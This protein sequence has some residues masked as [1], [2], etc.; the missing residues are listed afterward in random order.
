[1][2]NEFEFMIAGVPVLLSLKELDLAMQ[3]QA[4]FE[5]VNIEERLVSIF[6]KRQHGTNCYLGKMRV[7]DAVKKFS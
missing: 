3:H 4:R 2:R 5:V 7:T 6:D 1:M